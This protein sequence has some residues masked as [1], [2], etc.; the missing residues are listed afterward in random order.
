MRNIAFIS[1][2]GSALCIWLIILWTSLVL[3]NTKDVSSFWSWKFLIAKW[4]INGISQ[5]K[6]IW[7]WPWNVWL[8]ESGRFCGFSGFV[9]TY[10]GHCHFRFF[11]CDIQVI[12]R[13]ARSRI[14]F[15]IAYIWGGWFSS[16]LFSYFRLKLRFSS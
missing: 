1:K 14:S 7:F 11:V 6:L 8:S 5:C 2:T 9:Y 15:C 12:Q 3:L 10:D 16:L 13:I 4:V